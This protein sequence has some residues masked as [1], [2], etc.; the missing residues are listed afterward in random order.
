LFTPPAARPTYQVKIRFQSLPFKCNLQRYIVDAYIVDAYIADGFDPRP[1]RD[2]EQ[3]AKIA[4]NGGPL[5]RECEHWRNYRGD[6]C[7]NVETEVG[8]FKRCAACRAM[9]YWWGCVQVDFNLPVAYLRCDIL[10]SNF[11]LSYG[12]TCAATTCSPA[13]Q[14]P[15]W[16]RGHKRECGQAHPCENTVRLA[17][18]TTERYFSVK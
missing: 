7:T 2:I 18:F 9:V 12:S 17:L 11:A 14:K 16:K 8:A 4:D 1:A 3:A 6:M 15:D 5:F 13:C 10:V